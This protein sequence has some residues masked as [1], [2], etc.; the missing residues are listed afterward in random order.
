[1][2]DRP[3]ARIILF[4]PD[5]RILLFKYQ[6]DRILDPSLPADVVQP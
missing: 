4:D 5:E 3:T 6:S 1:M 2:I